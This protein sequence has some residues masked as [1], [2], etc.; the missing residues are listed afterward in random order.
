MS[1]IATVFSCLGAVF[2]VETL[3]FSAFDVI[4]LLSS[5]SKLF[6]A[7]LLVIPDGNGHFDLKNALRKKRDSYTAV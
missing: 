3:I 5:K 6:R 1:Q 7:I 2:I 4:S